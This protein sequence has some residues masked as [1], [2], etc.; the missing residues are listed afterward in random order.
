MK[1]M[2][3]GVPRVW[4]FWNGECK[5][6]FSCLPIRVQRV[7][8]R[9]YWTL[10]RG[11]MTNMIGCSHFVCRRI[12]RSKHRTSPTGLH[13]VQRPC[14]PFQYHIAS[15]LIHL[16]TL[17]NALCYW[18]GPFLILNLQYHCMLT[19]WSSGVKPGNCRSIRG[20]FAWGSLQQFNQF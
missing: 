11:P 19:V 10:F 13:F 4:T 8:Y 1:S 2:N 5:I 9:C 16:C 15:L 20:L 3:I 17:Y 18:Q 6:F 12:S 14:S 7:L